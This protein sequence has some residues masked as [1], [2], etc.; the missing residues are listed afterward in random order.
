M[1]ANQ[2]T[3]TGHKEFSDIIEVFVDFTYHY[4]VNIIVVCCCT[5]C[6]CRLCYCQVRKQ[7]RS[8]VN[9]VMFEKYRWERQNIRGI[10]VSNT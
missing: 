8:Y 2:Q 1:L 5:W 4:Y 9:V 10:C 7:H 6:I 3:N